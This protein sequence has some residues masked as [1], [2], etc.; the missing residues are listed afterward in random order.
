MKKLYKKAGSNTTASIYLSD[1]KE[2]LILLPVSRSYN[3]IKK[4]VYYLKRG[5]GKQKPTYL[6]GLFPTKDPAV[7]SGDVKNKITGMKQMFS[8]IFQDGGETLILEGL[9]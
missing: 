1:D 2:K 5:T 7:F 9:S 3:Q 4:P 6:S 8:V